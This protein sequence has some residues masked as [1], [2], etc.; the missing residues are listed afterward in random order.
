MRRLT[1]SPQE[2]REARRARREKIAR[3]QDN[4]AQGD[5]DD[6]VPIDIDEFRTTLARRITR[7]IGNRRESWRGWKEPACRRQRSCVGPH[8]RC[9]NAPP[10]PPDPTGRRAA[11]VMAQVQRALREVREKQEEGK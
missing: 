11:R 7:F 5:D 2:I 10:L 8:V 3:G 1:K 4:I 9:S 6:P